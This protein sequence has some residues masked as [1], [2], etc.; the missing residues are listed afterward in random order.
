MKPL[1]IRELT[2][3]TGR[4]KICVP[5]TGKTE[6]EILSQA[7]AAMKKEPDLLEWRVDF[8]EQVEK[9]E[10]IAGMCQKL[11]DKIGQIPLIF[12]FRSEKEGGNRQ[13]SLSDYVDLLKIAAKQPRTD[14]ID[15]ELF[16]EQPL[17]SRVIRDLQQMGKKV[18]A[19]NHHFEGTPK[20]EIM[21]TILSQME[22]AGADLRKLAVM[23]RNKEQVWDLLGATIQ[24]ADSGKKPVITMAMGQLGCASRILGELSGSCITFGTAGQSS[25][26]GQMEVGQLKEILWALRLDGDEE[27]ND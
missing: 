26:P 7:E 1:V 15:V 5:L 27:K 19:S 16:M 17:M 22:E 18:I 8:F 11:G 4:P 14:L 13:I 3:G 25:A 24:A 10:A 21:E 20:K 9:E 6:E 2:L 23:P 12:T